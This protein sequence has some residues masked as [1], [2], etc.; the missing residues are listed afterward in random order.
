LY[1]IIKDKVKQISI[2]Y[3]IIKDKVKGKKII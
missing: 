3:T 2:L 1:T